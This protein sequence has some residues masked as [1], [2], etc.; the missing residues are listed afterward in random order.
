MPRRIAFDHFKEFLDEARQAQHRLTRDDRLLIVDQAVKLLQGFYVHLPSKE[1]LYGAKPLDRLQQLAQEVKQ[2]A[3]PFKDD[4]LP[5]HT[6]MMAIFIELRDVHTQ[7]RPPRPYSNA[8]AFLPFK[9]EACIE[10]GQ[11]K[12]IVAHIAGGFAHPTFGK[13]VEVVQWNGVPVEQAVESAGRQ[14]ATA[15]A[16]HGLG[17]ARLTNRILLIHPVPE[18][19]KVQ[20]RYRADG[21]DLDLEYDWQVV[22]L[23]KGVCGACNEVQKFQDFQQFLFAPY[24]FCTAI[25]RSQWVHTQQDSFG[26]IRIFS[27]ERPLLGDDLFVG[28]IKK[29]IENFKGAR[30]LIIDVRDNGGGSTRGSERIIQFIKRNRADL[31]EPHRLC[32]RATQESLDLCRL[33]ATVLDVRDL[34]CDGMD[35]WVK[36]IEQAIQKKE[37]FSEAFRYTCL[38]AANDT[39]QIF[40]GPVIVLTSGLTYSAAE[41]FAAGFQDHGGM[42]LGVDETTG[43]GGAGIRT[44]ANFH[45]Y[46][47]S[48]SPLQD[49]TKAKGAGFQ[50]AFRASRRVGLSAGQDIE[51]VGVKGNLKRYE[52]TRNDLLYGNV[53]LKSHAAGLLA[54]MK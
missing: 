50:V 8:Y 40:G 32:F 47:G 52:M 26:Y 42:V 7:Y 10:N 51:D 29:Q 33:G 2:E 5:F 22:T 25:G 53:D 13:G 16:R 30:G 45:D 6:K 4:D 3:D 46:F 39:G 24:D 14:G 27:F 21:K 19:Q 11:R 49:L 20:I 31:V 38:S 18:Q 41:F 35:L 37:T 28:M 9:I 15:S 17:L 44:H 1:K 48:A 43:G 54:Q 34:G 23:Q 12:Y 36:S